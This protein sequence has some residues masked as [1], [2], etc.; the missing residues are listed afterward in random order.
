MPLAI[1]NHMMYTGWI[2]KAILLWCCFISVWEIMCSLISL[3]AF[4]T[5]MQ[6]FTM[7]A[8]VGRCS[9]SAKCLVLQSK[10]AV[11]FQ[12][13]QRKE[14]VLHWLENE[15]AGHFRRNKLVYLLDRVLNRQLFIRFGNIFTLV[16]SIHYI[17]LT[18]WCEWKEQEIC[19]VHKPHV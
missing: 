6:Y 1:C 11:L 2:G 8:K 3:Y 5:K 16:V 7:P 19:M 14:V 9:E 12:T 13:G 15:F 17:N 18:A 10:Y 4:G